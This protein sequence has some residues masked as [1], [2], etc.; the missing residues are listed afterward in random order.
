MTLLRDTLSRIY[1][2]LEATLLL[3]RDA[4]LDEG[5]LNLTGSSRERWSAILAEATKQNRLL[6]IT[7][8]AR[9]DYPE[10][11]DLVAIERLL[12]IQ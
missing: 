9:R 3:M 11:P 5:R 12:S 7:L 10:D 2:S 8:S 6:A 4:G 1:S